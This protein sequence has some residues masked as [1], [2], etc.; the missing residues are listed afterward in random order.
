MAW[1]AGQFERHQRAG[2][3]VLEMRLARVSQAKEYLYFQ[4]CSPFEIGHRPAA[5][6][7][8]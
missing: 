6:V 5:W 3:S 7:T 4:G 1:P 8:H 2:R